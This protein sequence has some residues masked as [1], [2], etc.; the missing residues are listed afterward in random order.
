MAETDSIIDMACEALIIEGADCAGAS[1]SRHVWAECRRGEGRGRDGEVNREA[2]V[3][4]TQV[5]EEQKR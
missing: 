5:E 4:V 2:S 1:Q 3:R